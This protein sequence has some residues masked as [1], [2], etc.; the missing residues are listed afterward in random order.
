M[1]KWLK[2]C[3][4]CGRQVKVYGSSLRTAIEKPPDQPGMTRTNYYGGPDEYYCWQCVREKRYPEDHT[5]GT[6]ADD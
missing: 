6:T 3:R 5:S 2:L 1:P 4:S